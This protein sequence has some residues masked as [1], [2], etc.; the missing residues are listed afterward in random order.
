MGAY[1]I[2]N[3]K[4]LV[5]AYPIHRELTNYGIYTRTDTAISK[6]STAQSRYGRH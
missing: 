2:V 1:G 6:E 3:D 4:G 5:M